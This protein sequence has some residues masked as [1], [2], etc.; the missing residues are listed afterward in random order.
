MGWFEGKSNGREA[1]G[2]V[3][4]PDEEPFTQLWG[5][6]VAASARGR[7]QSPLGS[8]DGPRSNCGPLHPTGVGQSSSHVMSQQCPLTA[9]CSWRCPL[10]PFVIVTQ[11]LGRERGW[12]VG[13]PTWTPRGWIGGVGTSFSQRTCKCKSSGTICTPIRKDLVEQVA[14]HPSLEPHAAVTRELDHVF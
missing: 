6:H 7:L 8:G 10:L 11:T 1:A 14:V 5:L 4:T 13:W 3:C 9:L 12:S 2:Q